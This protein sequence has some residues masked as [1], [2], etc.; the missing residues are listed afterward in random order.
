MGRFGIAV[1]AAGLELITVVWA[2]ELIVGPCP[3][4]AKLACLGSTECV[5]QHWHGSGC[6]INR[7][8]VKDRL[9]GA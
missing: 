4:K 8:F 2:G 3:L 5:Q 1:N 9:Q 6:E 7:P